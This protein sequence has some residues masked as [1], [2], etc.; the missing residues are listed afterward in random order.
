MTRGLDHGIFAS[1]SILFPP[2]SPQAL[3]PDIPIVQ[4]SLPYPGNTPERY[5]ALGKA[6]QELRG[7]GIAILCS[8]M[9]VHNLRDLFRSADPTKPQ[10]Y[11]ASFDEALREAV[12]GSGAGTG[13]SPEVD[14]ATR[15]NRMSNLLQ[16]PDAKRAHPSWE[17]LWPVF[18]AA[19]AAGNQAGRRIWTK[20]EGSLS[21]GM[22]RFG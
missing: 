2:N 22:F 7:E 19:G 9:A 8:G 13:D 11:A 1:F 12:E 17:H 4:V 20:V 21:W 18:I 5:F 10:S 15:E 16:R 6:L 14:V 3:Y